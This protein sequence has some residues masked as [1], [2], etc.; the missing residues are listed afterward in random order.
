MQLSGTLVTYA[1]FNVV[2]AEVPCDSIGA[3]IDSESLKHKPHNGLQLLVWRQ[4]ESL[5]GDV[6]LV[7]HGWCNAKLAPPGLAQRS[8]LQA[9]LHPLLLRFTHC[10]FEPK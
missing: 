7:A 3:A 2:T 6:P 4:N 1:Q 10:P 9:Q 5:R 8:S